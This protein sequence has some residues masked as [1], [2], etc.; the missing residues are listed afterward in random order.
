M[1]GGMHNA[2]F[3]T[4]RFLRTSPFIILLILS[5]VQ[6]ESL[7]EKIGWRGATGPMIIVISMIFIAI[8]AFL[9]LYYFQQHFSHQYAIQQHSEQLFREVTERLGFSH[10]EIQKIRQLL[11]HEHIAD[12]QVILQ[13]ISLFEKCIDKEVQA[14]LSKN[15][16]P[17]VRKEENELLFSIRRKAG[18]H[19]LAL[20]HPLASS[21]NIAIGQGGSLYGRNLKKPLINRATVVDSN[22]FTFTLQYNVDKEDVCYINPGDEIKFA[23]TRQ[24]D[25]VY[26]VPL[27]VVAADGSGTIEVN[28]TINLR[29]NQLR[30]YVRIDITL[31]LK[32]RLVNTVDMQKSE[33]RRGE[34]VDAKMSDISGGGLSFIGE[35]SLRVGDIVS[36]G[37]DL[38]N[39]KFIGISA[40]VLRISLQEGKTAT[41]YKHHVQ[42]IN[43]EPRRR[44]MIVKYVFDKQRQINQWR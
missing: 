26:G 31:P 35:R 38:P 22:E 10:R 18:F 39:A 24:N 30:Q 7:L 25:S 42:F 40:K 37:F 20:E 32:L 8:F 12:P 28:H 27:A 41:Y 19:H 5:L 9:L 21:R 15:V 43:L 6:A 11:K 33:I 2:M 1:K 14:L 36:L 34:S 44:D 3:H 13:S 4:D 16:L 17:D 29:R 23:F